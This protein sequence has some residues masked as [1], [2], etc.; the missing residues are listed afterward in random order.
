MQ[1]NFCKKI[2]E[3]PINKELIVEIGK[4]I[5]NCYGIESLIVCNT[6]IKY[7]SPYCNSGNEIIKRQGRLV[8]YY[9]TEVTPEWKI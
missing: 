7:Y 4:K 3:N 2:Y 9:F 1:H 5:F 8:E 6:I